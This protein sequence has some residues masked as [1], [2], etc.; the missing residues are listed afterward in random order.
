M[1]S[2][3]IETSTER[4]VVGI[5]E[6]GN[7]LF[8]KE[9]PLGLN[10]AKFLAPSIVEGLKVLNLS[11]SSI[12]GIAVGIGPGSYTGIRAGAMLAKALAYAANCPLIGVSTLECFAPTSDGPFT[13]LIDARIGGAYFIKGIQEKGSIQHTL[14]P[15]V[16]PLESLEDFLNETQYVVT[17]QAKILKPK[18]EVFCPKAL[19]EE[20]PPNLLQMASVAERNR[21]AGHLAV[22]E[23]LDLMYLRKTGAELEK[24][25]Q[26]E[27]IDAQK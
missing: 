8:Q 9:L 25:A 27:R 21:I 5:V 24:E 26:K 17:P 1:P 16:L 6:G 18:L 20:L 10:N 3:L 23:A 12:S 22:D 2:L 11:M 14:Q 7:L 19:W 4:A 13:V 15:Q